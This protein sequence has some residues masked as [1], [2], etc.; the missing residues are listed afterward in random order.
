V[1]E[2]QY[3]LFPIIEKENLKEGKPELWRK[4]CRTW[5]PGSTQIRGVEFVDGDVKKTWGV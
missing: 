4:I 3:D 1:F 2:W 5:I